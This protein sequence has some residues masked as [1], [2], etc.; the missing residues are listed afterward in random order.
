MKTHTANLP[1]LLMGPMVRRAEQTGVCIQFATSKP[2]S[3][4]INLLNVECY[5]EQQTIA[6]GQ[7]LYLH[8]I[9]IK[10]VDNLFPVDKLLS[11]ELIIDDAIIDLSPWCYSNQTT[12]AFVIPNKLSDILHG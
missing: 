8:F 3:C 6:L 2:A 11:Y 4:Q 12:P 7:H 1:I 10:P 5:S 9:V